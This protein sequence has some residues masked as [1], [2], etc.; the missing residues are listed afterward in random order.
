L[1]PWIEQASRRL[2][3]NMLA[4]TRQQARPHRLGSC[5]LLRGTTPA[6]ACSIRTQQQERQS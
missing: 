5:A 6:K 1:W 3:R 2:H 4:I